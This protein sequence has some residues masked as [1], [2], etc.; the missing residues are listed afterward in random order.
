MGPFML[1]TSALLFLL[2][3]GCDAGQARQDTVPAPLT[4]I[5]HLADHLSVQNFWVDGTSGFQAGRGARVVCCVSLPRQWH[6]GLTV[7]VGWNVTNW[8]D[9]GWETRERRVPVERYEKVGAMYVHFLSDGKV[10]VVSSNVGPGI[11][12]PNEDYPGPH[13]A[14]PKKNPWHVY[15]PP[16]AR[17]PRQG[18]PTVMEQAK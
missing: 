13:D 10:R 17:C 8:R 18:S 9:C 12:Q 11:F 1:R 6:P 16:S 7:V 2:L 3:A 4:G 14:I 15:G 5:D